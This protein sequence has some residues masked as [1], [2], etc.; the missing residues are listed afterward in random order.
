M[1]I[2]DV[3]ITVLSG[4]RINILPITYLQLPCK[5]P[6]HSQYRT[7]RQ[8]RMLSLLPS[9]LSTSVLCAAVPF[10]LHTWPQKARADLFHVH[11]CLQVEAQPLLCVYPRQSNPA[12]SESIDWNHAH[13]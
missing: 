11:L 4:F 8:M 10:S 3:K 6:C 5:V 1:N 2:E 7:E 12:E 9:L 13:T